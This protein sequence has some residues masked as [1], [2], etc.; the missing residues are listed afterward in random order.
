M[1]DYK[2]QLLRLQ[3][4]ICDIKA[5][6]LLVNDKRLIYINDTKKLIKEYKI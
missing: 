1:D 3:V 2:L 5:H 6:K 4:Q